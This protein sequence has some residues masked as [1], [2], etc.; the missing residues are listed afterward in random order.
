MKISCEGFNAVI[1]K[2]SNVPHAL[3]AGD[4]TYFRDFAKVIRF[5]EA[6]FKL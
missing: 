6:S 5:S 4:V 2:P 3:P 1:I